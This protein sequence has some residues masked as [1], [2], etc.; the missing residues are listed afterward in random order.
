MLD[1]EERGEIT[2]VRL[3]HGKVNA[4]DV[5]L[6]QAIEK[7]FSGLDPSRAVV[8]TGAGRSLSAG[9]DLK[10]ITDGGLEYVRVF[11]PALSAA[12][13][14]VF[15]HPGPV[16]AAVNGHAIAGGCVLVAACDIRLMSAGTIGLSELRVGV[17]FPGV[18]LEVMRHVLGP[19]TPRFVLGSELVSP[20][21]AQAAGLIHR[22]AEPESLLDEALAEAKRLARISPEVYAF[23]KRQLQGP[24][25]ER[26]EALSPADDER[27]TQ[28]WASPAV[29]EAINGFMDGLKQR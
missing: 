13:K 19:A 22:V 20:E 10:R 25:R 9:V 28:M 4:L 24:A 16:V 2:I 8:L 7:T 3:A 27:S 17:P 12:I 26:I 18:P 23:T 11:R 6:L 14:S 5:E 21:E 29:R 1:L 15:Y